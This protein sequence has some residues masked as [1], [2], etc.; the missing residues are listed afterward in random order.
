MH[1]QSWCFETEYADWCGAAARKILLQKEG[2]RLDPLVPIYPLQGFNFAPSAC[3]APWP[4]LSNLDWWPFLATQAKP[5]WI[6]YMEIKDKA[7]K[8]L[9]RD[10]ILD[11]TELKNVLVIYP[12][13]DLTSE[14]MQLCF[15]NYTLRDCL[16]TYLRSNF[17]NLQ[18]F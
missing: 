2:H 18:S 10:S 13:C 17:N 16:Y 6:W 5:I 12:F 14:G 3:S 7:V 15:C 11:L 4:L 1:M 9:S 8:K